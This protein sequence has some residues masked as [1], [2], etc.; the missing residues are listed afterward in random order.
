M[1]DARGGEHTVTRMSRRTTGFTLVELIITLVLVGVVGAVA[2]QTLSPQ[3]NVGQSASAKSVLEQV[4]ARQDVELTTRGNFTVDT[5][6]LANGF[7]GATF[8][9]GT[10]DEG[11]IS[12]SLG[13]VEGVENFGAAYN[14]GGR[15]YTVRA[16]QSGEP[17]YGSF[18]ASKVTCNG[19][20][21]LEGSST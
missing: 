10:A 12:V 6:R 9:S 4:I 15:C 17:L 19:N 1:G 7:S 13:D 3:R 18:D 16:A 11:E 14:A 8:V 20:L 2:Y 21:A 5:E